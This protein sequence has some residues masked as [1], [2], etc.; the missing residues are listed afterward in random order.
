MDKREKAE[1]KI[2]ANKVRQLI[3]EGVFNAKSGHPGGS[4]SA[5]DIFTYLYFKELN[6]DPKNPKWAD[7]DRFVLSKGHC[8]PGLYAALAIK[9]YFPEKEIKSLR[10]IGAML[11]GHP[12]MKGTP[13]VDMSSGS[14]GQ[15]VSAACGMA[16]AAK[17]DNASYR[18][19]A[20]LGDGEC[21]EGQVWE[22]AMFAAH[23][24][25]DNLCYIVDYNGLQI[26][27][28]VSEVAGLEPLDKKFESFGFEV[29]K[30]CGHC[31]NQI[32]EAFEKAKSVKGK[33]TVI[34]A[35]TV[36]GKGVSYMED[37]V[38]WHGKAPNQEQYELA[39]NELKEQQKVLE[40]QLA[41]IKD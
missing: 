16:L 24:N 22:S 31:F 3:I 9:G 33:P 15:G 32:E 18:V 12:D 40:A 36:K 14:L 37:Q 30:I 39:L 27:G 28:K 6:V 11:Q 26:D 2:T 10:H 17:M 25:L 21:E 20:M 38:G 35:E 41:E 34:I 5:A 4:L 8:C 23:H 19:Y 29:I 1:L 7:R 13:G